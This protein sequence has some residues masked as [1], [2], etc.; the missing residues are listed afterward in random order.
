MVPRGPARSV[1]AKGVAAAEITNKRGPLGAAT[2]KR[3]MMVMTRTMSPATTS[4]RKPQRP[5][6]SKVAPHY[7]RLTA[8]SSSGRVRSRWWNHHSMHESR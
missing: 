4:F 7:I 2:R 5:C 8:N 3:Q 6:A 1:A